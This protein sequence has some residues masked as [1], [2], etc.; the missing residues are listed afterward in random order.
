MGRTVHAAVL[1]VLVS[2]CSKPSIEPGHWETAVRIEGHGGPAVSRR[3][4]LCVDDDDGE[5]RLALILRLVEWSAT[6]TWQDCDLRQ[7][8][9]RGDTISVRALCT[10]RTT[11]YPQPTS[12]A[13]NFDGTL[14]AT[15]LEGRFSVEEGGEFPKS[16]SGTM[17]SRRVGE[18]P[19]RALR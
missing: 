1:F 9:Y 14:A 13:L 16:R 19:D 4:L 6:D 10:G 2:A 11:V 12:T 5:A 18:C 7:P 15:R 17:T 8:S 3:E